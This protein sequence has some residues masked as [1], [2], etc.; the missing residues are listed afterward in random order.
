VA[1][2]S[3]RIT[4]PSNPYV[5]YARKLQRRRVR[6][7]EGRC[8]VEGVRLVD[9]VH[10]A[11]A[12]LLMVFW[13]RSLLQQPG[14]EDLLRSLEERRPPGGLFEV[15]P[16]ILEPKILEHLADTET[17]QGVVGVAA[18][19]TGDARALLATA[20]TVVVLDSLRDPGNVGTVIRSA[21]P[22]T[23]SAPRPS[24]PLWGR[25]STCPWSPPRRR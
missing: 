1:T 3:D 4:S 20:A 21:E 19:P 14:G 6:E 12:F 11:G 5:K 15:E 13:E 16:K 17:P 23:R 10:R 18:R 25:P 24:G 9:D 22:P 8:L 7:K 2:R